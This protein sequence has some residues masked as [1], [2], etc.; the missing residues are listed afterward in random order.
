MSSSEIPLKIF[1]NVCCHLL[2]NF[3]LFLNFC[4]LWTF[5]KIKNRI[6]LYSIN[7]YVICIGE[8]TVQRRVRGK[9]W[10]RRGVGPCAQ[11]RTWWAASLHICLI[12]SLSPE[13][14]ANVNRASSALL[15]I[16]RRQHTLFDARR[17]Q[18]SRQVEASAGTSVQPVT[19]WNHRLTLVVFI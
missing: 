4:T 9:P 3:R 10:Y 1:G 2:L 11:S 19:K 5:I 18:L 14:I 17:L 15:V 6:C 8:S 7:A 12:V 16:F 13:S